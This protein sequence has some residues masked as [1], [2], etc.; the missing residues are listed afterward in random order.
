[1]GFTVYLAYIGQPFL[2]EYVL[3]TALPYLKLAIAQ[4]RDH[5]QLV[6]MRLFA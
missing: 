4:K 5:V 2:C 3:Y 1:M 6:N